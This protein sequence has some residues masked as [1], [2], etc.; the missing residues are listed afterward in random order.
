[1]PDPS[2]ADNVERLQDEIDE[3]LENLL[4]FP[5]L[6]GLNRCADLMEEYFRLEMKVLTARGNDD[7]TIVEGHER[8]RV[9]TSATLGRGGRKDPFASCD[10]G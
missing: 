2:D 9:I 5:T 3:S 1:M 8:I 10:S 4:I 7:A 6:K